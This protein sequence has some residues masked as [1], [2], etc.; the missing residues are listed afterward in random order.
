MLL[1]GGRLMYSKF[2]PIHIDFINATLGFRI[3]QIDGVQL[4]TDSEPVITLTIKRK[5]IAKDFDAFYIEI[6]SIKFKKEIDTN[7]AL[8]RDSV[9]TKII[10]G[11]FPIKYRELGFDS[12][13]DGT[14]III[15]IESGWRHKYPVAFRNALKVVS[16]PRE[17]TD[18]KT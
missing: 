15:K 9:P 13:K 10:L 5:P 1:Y 2:F 12:I 14:E 18:A 7:E 16:R 8:H 11:L 3:P 6:P 17:E 4:L